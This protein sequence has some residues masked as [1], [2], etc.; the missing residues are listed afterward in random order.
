MSQATEEE[1]LTHRA[2]ALSQG[3]GVDRPLS[4]CGRG[5]SGLSGGHTR[6]SAQTLWAPGHSV[7]TPTREAVGAR[8]ELGRVPTLV[9]LFPKDP[10]SRRPH[11]PPPLP[12][13][14]PHL[15]FNAPS[16]QGRGTPTPPGCSFFMGFFPTVYMETVYV[17]Q[18]RPLWKKKGHTLNLG[19]GLQGGP[20]RLR[21]QKQ[22]RGWSEH[23]HS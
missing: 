23:K 4:P 17:T 18:N 12:S 10:W 21:D 22:P 13:T 19:G 2:E 8:A 9:P 15:N 7:M 14:H 1:T 3:W 6:S 16:P 5:L 20:Y 11:W